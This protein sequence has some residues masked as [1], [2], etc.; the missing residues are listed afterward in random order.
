MCAS[1]SKENGGTF[2][3]LVCSN[4]RLGGYQEFVALEI[5]DFFACR[6]PSA[7]VGLLARSSG[8]TSTT[9]R[10]FLPVRRKSGV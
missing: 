8:F 9:S 3:T 5:E 2:V 4:E 10:R 6:S 1:V 7:V